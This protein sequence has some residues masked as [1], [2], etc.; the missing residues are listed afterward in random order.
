E[1]PIHEPGLEALIRHNAESGRI[2][3]TT[4]AAQGVEHGLFQLIAVGTPPDEDGSADLRYVL[5][6][7]RSIARHM[8]RY[9]VVVTKSTVP[10]GTADKVRRE[11]EAALK[12]RGA[13]VE[14]DVVSNP[15]FLKEGAA[16]QDFMKPDRVVVGTD[17]P[18]TT[19]L[20]RALYEPFTRNHDRLIVMDIRS[21]ELT[22]YAANAM[23]AT[24]ISFMNELANLAERLGADIE[25]VRVGIGSDPRIGYSFIYPGTGYGGSCFPKDVR[26]LI[27][28]AREVDHEPQILS[29]VESVNAR[30]KEVL[31]EK[32]RQHFGEHLKGRTIALWGL[33][34]KPNTDDMREAPSRTIIERLLEAGARVRAYDPVAAAEARRLYDGRERFELARNAYEAVEGADALAIV[35]EWQEFRSPDFERLKQLLKTPLIFDGRNLYDPVMVGRFGL[36]YHAIGRGQSVER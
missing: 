1:V 25:K 15:E 18:R 12:E 27:R 2:E 17:N 16:V 32:M 14:F 34:F 23:L 9:C 31:V 8:S 21:A 10:V 20:M 35:T 19:E 28:S 3:F 11:I 6:A 26:A 22:K 24:K 7:A 4:D 5:A 36:T 33:A 29:A 30:Q 13:G